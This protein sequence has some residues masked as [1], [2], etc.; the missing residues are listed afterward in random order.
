MESINGKSGHYQLV[1][2][3]M[4]MAGQERLERP[5]EPSRATRLLRA[6]LMMEETL[7][8]IRA[9][10]VR[11][12]CSVPGADVDSFAFLYIADGAFNLAE[13][14]DGCCD[15]KVV[16]TG[17]LVACGVADEAAQRA[18]DLHNLGKFGPGHAIRADG[19]LVKPPGYPAPDLS[20]V[21]G[22]GS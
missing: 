18:V 16:T 4:K 9:L 13:V 6:R 5:G 11:V 22:G 20:A 2:Q 21:L 10:G 8:T 17:T 1:E 12:K 19:K 7:E 15:V 14:V 3:F